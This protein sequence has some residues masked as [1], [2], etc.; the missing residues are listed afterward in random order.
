LDGGQ[1]AES[2]QQAS[3]SFHA[4]VTQD[5]WVDK[6]ESARKPLGK[7][8]SRKVEK[9][10]PNGPY[11]VAKFDTSFEALKAASETVTCV[12]ETNGQWRTVAYLI[13]PRSITN[14]AAVEPAQTWLQGIDNGN[15]AQSWTNA[16][17]YFQQ[18]ITSE[19]WVE[20]VQQVRKPLGALVS[21]KVKS[22]QEL[23]SLPGAPDGR[24][25]VM[26]FET[27]FA[28]KKSAIETVTFMLEKDGKWKAAGYFIK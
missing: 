18:A 6:V 26:Q 24:Y 16:A 22:A 20:A 7:L 14:N 17:A 19:K 23:A 3:E 13:V 1:Y 21:R 12:L 9:A 15:Y 10:E 27:S 8:L 2:W 11:F 5:D 28:N 25:I 4:M